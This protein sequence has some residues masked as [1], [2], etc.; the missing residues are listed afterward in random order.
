MHPAA[1]LL[2]TPQHH[3]TSLFESCHANFLV[4]LAVTALGEGA[5]AQLVKFGQPTNKEQTLVWQQCCAGTMLMQSVP[6][7]DRQEGQSATGMSSMANGADRL[8]PQPAVKRCQ[9]EMLDSCNGTTS[10][11]RQCPGVFNIESILQRSYANSMITSAPVPCVNATAVSGDQ[12]VTSTATE[13]RFTLL[14]T[15]GKLLSLGLLPIYYF[16]KVSGDK[17]PMI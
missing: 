11:K 4:R 5:G 3:R 16:S 13:V 10:I 12:L 15:L 14:S 1:D 7:G 2:L 6:C 9:Y 17:V 8:M